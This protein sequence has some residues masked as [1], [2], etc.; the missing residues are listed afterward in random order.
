MGLE[1]VPSFQDLFQARG[2]HA[3]TGEVPGFSYRSPDGV[4]QRVVLSPPLPPE[5]YRLFLP[6]QGRGC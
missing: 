1:V 4:E 5:G 3:S 2:W 6:P